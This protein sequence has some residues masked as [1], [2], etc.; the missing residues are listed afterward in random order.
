M[1]IQNDPGIQ[2]WVAQVLGK[3]DATIGKTGLNLF[4]DFSRIV[5]FSAPEANA[6]DKSKMSGAFFECGKDLKALYKQLQSDPEMA[7]E[8]QFHAIQGFDAISA[9]KD[10]TWIMVVMD[11]KTLLLGTQVLVDAALKVARKEVEPLSKHAGYQE[12]RKREEATKPIWGAIIPTMEWRTGAKANE[13]AK[14]FG[15]MEFIIVGIGL[16]PKPQVVAR[17]KLADPKAMPT[18]KK[19]VDTFLHSLQHWAVPAPKVLEVVNRSKIK[20]EGQFLAVTL[21]VDKE[22]YDQARQEW[23]KKLLK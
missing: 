12:L 21:E 20:E 16:S 9:K 6:P 14:P 19:S 22:L 18:V 15:D 7:K 13:V 2:K 11:P 8:A 17:I 10:P 5:L 4:K 3:P 1:E 23:E